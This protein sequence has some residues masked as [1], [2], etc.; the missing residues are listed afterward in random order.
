V[1]FKYLALSEENELLLKRYPFISCISYGGRGYIGVVQNLDD[2]LTSFY[3]F[4]SLR[5]LDQ[6]TQFLELGETWWWESNR[7]VPINLFLKTDWEQFRFTLK[8]FNSRDAQLEHGP[9]VSLRELVQKRY[10]RRS[11]TLV[12]KISGH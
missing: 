12:K 7:K 1:T 2:V 9:Y 8:V 11:V 4:G 10:K 6:R 5:T 3:D